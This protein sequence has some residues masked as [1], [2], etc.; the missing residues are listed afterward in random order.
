MKDYTLYSSDKSE[1]ILNKISNPMDCLIR[2]RYLM[3]NRGCV[4]KDDLK[5]CICNFIDESE[6]FLFL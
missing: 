4:D 5:K 6:H 1:K 3:F 2:F